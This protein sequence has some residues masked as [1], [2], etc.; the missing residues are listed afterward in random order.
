MGKV[1]M[2]KADRGIAFYIE[3]LALL[4]VFT[5]VIVVLMNGFSSARK[6]S[7]KAAVLSKAVHLAENAAEM[8]S[9]S[10]SGEMLFDL[11]NENGN[12]SALEEAGDD[13]RSIY[14]AKYDEDMM[15]EADGTF[16][17][18]VS[19]MPE[20]GGMAKSEISVYWNG[21]TEPVYALELGIYIGNAD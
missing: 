15:P 6:L 12:A 7:T 4:T 16:C 17:V 20:A 3:A 19:W 1:K 2:S 13:L 5:A 8:A 14:R 11:L 10:K 21:S 9:S 18:D